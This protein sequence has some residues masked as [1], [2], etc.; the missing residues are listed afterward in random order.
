MGRITLSNFPNANLDGTGQTCCI[1]SQKIR[2]RSSGWVGGCELSECPCPKRRQLVSNVKGGVEIAS[3]SFCCTCFGKGE[4]GR[5]RVGR[6]QLFLLFHGL[7]SRTEAPHCNLHCRML[8]P[9][10]SLPHPLEIRI[11]D[12]A[13]PEAVCL[14]NNCTDG[15]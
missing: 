3:P 6:F 11:V 15:I 9:T 1:E 12:N 13:P 4:K 14:F 2:G 5:R 8:P 10:L 7:G